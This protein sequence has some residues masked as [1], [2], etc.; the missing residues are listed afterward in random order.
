MTEDR[1][2]FLLTTGESI[3]VEYKQAHDTVPASLYETVCAFLNREG[4]DIILGV[5][6]SGVSIGVDPNAAPRM[7]A[8]IASSTNDGSFLDPPFMLSPIVIVLDGRTLILVQ[9][10]ES[11]RVHRLK[12]TIYDRGADGDF[13]QRSPERIA[14]LANR[15]QNFYSE[16]KF[17]PYLRISDLDER[18]INK[19][20]NLMS[21]RKEDH[22]WPALSIEAMLRSA[23]LLA[24][25]FATGQEGLC[26][27]AGL[28]FGTEETLSS[29]VPQYKTDALLRRQ[30]LDRYDDRIDVRVNL[31]EAYSVLLG[32]FEKHMSD[33]FYLEGTVR[34][35]LRHKVF[36]ELV[37][38]SLIHREYT[39]GGTS[40]FIIY[41]DRVEMENPSI[42]HQPG[43]L[44]PGVSAPF[45]KN[46]LISKFFLQMGWVEEIGSGLINVNKYLP[47]YAPGGSAE[48]IEGDSFKT[49]VHLTAQATLQATP[50]VTPQATPQA[51][52]DRQV[53][54]L[55]FCS[56]PRSREAIQAF[57]GLQDREHFRKEVLAPLLA[58]GLLEQTIPD[59]PNSPKQRYVSR[60]PLP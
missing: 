41:G 14:L 27:A 42:P 30:D 8:S 12:G 34:I 3:R 21:S 51:M 38:N 33:P 17:Y 10:P 49:I 11:S 24:R 23:G 60:K 59:K 15:K 25:D 6:D 32:F 26:L 29:L 1:V 43:L 46:P 55:A 45:Q 50:Q 20:R 58:S 52:E 48:F 39:H 36:R 4:G 53:A 9:V 16:A 2:R 57:L 19:A 54:I 7:C 44:Q 13:K 35:S 56:V 47:L 40:R 18:T 5:E 31:I 22:P 37:A 28:L